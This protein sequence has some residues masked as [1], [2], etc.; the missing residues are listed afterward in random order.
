MAQT[1]LGPSLIIPAI[2]ADNS[3]IF[4]EQL[5]I[6][7]QLTSRIQIDVVD[8]K[9]VSFL[10]V[11]PAEIIKKYAAKQFLEAHLMIEKPAEKLSYYQSLGFKKI[12]PHYEALKNPRT[13]LSQKMVSIAINP[14]TSIEELAPFI[15]NLATVLIMGVNPGKSG[16]KFIPQTLSKIRQLR[17]LSDKIEIEVDG[18]VK[19]SNIS[20]IIKAGA[21]V[22]VCGSAIF[23]QENPQK[24]FANLRREIGFGD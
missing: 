12:I 3:Q 4:E 7:S 11:C 24:N 2:L 9:F 23:N 22:I 16:Q 6:A 8:N 15:N 13:Y 20:Q 18:G 14:E 1:S 5:K 17:S 10:G 21:D 19:S